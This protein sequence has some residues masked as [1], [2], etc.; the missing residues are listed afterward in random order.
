[1]KTKVVNIITTLDDGGAEA[2]LFKLLQNNKKL[3]FHLTVISLMDEGK[4]GSL[5]K[6]N[7]IDV[8]TLNMNRGKLSLM[9]IYKF[10]KILKKN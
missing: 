9:H 2:T 6:K 7:N 8:I 4:Y 5:L 10:Y 1:M 3:D